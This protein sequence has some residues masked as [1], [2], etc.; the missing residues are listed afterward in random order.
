[1]WL[2]Q[3]GSRDIDDI[4]VRIWWLGD[5]VD[6]VGTS[7]LTVGV[8]RYK[9]DGITPWIGLAWMSLDSTRLTDRRCV[10][11]L[12]IRVEYVKKCRGQQIWSIFK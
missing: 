5:E 9:Q 6:F 4:Q 8:S 11:E 3:P 12:V 10:V 7:I 2:F 1:M